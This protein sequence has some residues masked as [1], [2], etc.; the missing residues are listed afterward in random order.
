MSRTLTEI[1]LRWIVP[2]IRSTRRG[3]RIG[4][5]A[6]R[7][8]AR[9]CALGFLVL[10][11]G[12]FFNEGDWSTLLLG[13]L[14]VFFGLIS[15]ALPSGDD[16]K[17]DPQEGDALEAH[18]I[19]GTHEIVVVGRGKTSRRIHVI[20][21]IPIIT[22]GW[23][24]DL[25]EDQ[26]SEVE[27]VAASTPGMSG[28][29]PSISFWIVAIRGKRSLR[30][31][32]EAGWTDDS[33]RFAGLWWVVGGI[34]LLASLPALLAVGFPVR[35]LRE[36]PAAWSP[37]PPMPATDGR[38]LPADDPRPGDALVL[39]AHFAMDERI[40][41]QGGVAI[42][43]WRPEQRDSFLLVARGIRQRMEQASRAADS[44]R[45]VLWAFRPS[46]HDPDLLAR[47]FEFDSWSA[48]IFRKQWPARK[49][50]RKRMLASID[51][52]LPGDSV[53]AE[54]LR[55]VRREFEAV[56]AS[57]G[58]CAQG[59]ASANALHRKVLRL[60]HPDSSNLLVRSENAIIH[61]A[62]TRS[63]QW[64]LGVPLAA[65]ET[66]NSIAL[67][68]GTMLE[69]DSTAPLHA[70]PTGFHPDEL[71]LLHPKT[72]DWTTLDSLPS[73]FR[74]AGAHAVWSRVDGPWSVVRLGEP[75]SLRDL[76]L[77][78]LVWVA[79]IAALP[80]WLVVGTWKTLAWRRA[81]IFAK[82]ASTEWWMQNPE[83]IHG[84]GGDESVVLSISS[85]SLDDAIAFSERISDSHA[86]V[87]PPRTPG[88]R[89]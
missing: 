69:I 33:A 2:R 67:T 81:S 6:A 36:L 12:E 3:L 82:A 85:T 73:A 29:L 44:A 15:L 24:D 20:G 5:T 37:R 4:W 28:S 53:W 26:E 7:W 77:S 31:E 32:L 49:A 62:W 11:V 87:R 50:E 58:D 52:L 66:W 45:A 47:P 46:F 84:K 88:R 1:E 80:I 13:A 76:L 30:A 59:H 64:I 86:G 34:A 83:G 61:G 8:I 25:P 56:D 55:D 60:L 43:P 74:P 38:I 54:F 10:G 51:T 63:V 18:W 9:A 27:V 71:W 19:R 17:S 14:G 22:P 39:G 65:G 23:L 16:G 72:L 21:G 70:I 35:E 89:P 68:S 75:V 42:L 41:P 79:L 57:G 78:Q 48:S 40:N